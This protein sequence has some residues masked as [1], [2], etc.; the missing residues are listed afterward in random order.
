MHT[1]RG[2]A[3]ASYNPYMLESQ[4]YVTAQLKAEHTKTMS[5][6][7]TA[8]C[9]PRSTGQT[10]RGFQTAGRKISSFTENCFSRLAHHSQQH[11]TLIKITSRLFIWNWS[12]PAVWPAATCTRAPFS[13][14]T[15]LCQQEPGSN[16]CP[17]VTVLHLKGQRGKSGPKIYSELS[18]GVALGGEQHSPPDFRDNASPFLSVE[19]KCDVSATP[20]AN[21]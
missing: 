6:A 9:C 18:R 10:R 2:S 17:P 19:R 14:H 20:D 1:R 5:N 8:A 4:L 15:L 12:S 7:A 16:S 21:Q 11:V 13:T 3:V